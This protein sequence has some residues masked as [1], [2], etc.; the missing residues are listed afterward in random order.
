MPTDPIQLHLNE[1]HID[2]IRL[3]FGGSEMIQQK[4]FCSSAI[5]RF[6][7]FFIVSALYTVLSFQGY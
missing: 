6:G 4:L 2:A 7:L 3:R 5:F 1:D